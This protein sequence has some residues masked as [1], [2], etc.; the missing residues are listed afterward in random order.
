MRAMILAAGLGTRL[1]PLTNCRPKALVPLRTVTMLQFW[2]ERLSQC[3]FESVC[4]NAFHRKQCLGAAVGLKKWPLPVKV[5]YEPLLLGTAGGIRLGA[6]HGGDTPLAV[7]NADVLSNA[8]LGLLY[9]RHRLSG[10][11]VSL[12]LHDCPQFNNVAVGIDGFV[13]GFGKEAKQICKKD[14]HIRLLAFTGIH[15]LNSSVLAGIPPGVACDIIQV[16]RELIAKNDP[17]AAL[18][19]QDLFWREMGSIQSY[20]KLTLELAKLPASFLAPIIT[21]QTLTIARQARIHPSCRLEGSV[22]IS[23]GVVAGEGVSLENVIIWDNV[24]IEKGSYLKNCIVTDG[25]K[26]F[27]RHTG[28]IFAPEPM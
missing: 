17:P 19:Q 23:P 5:L 27:G 13:L 22:V 2:I 11:G 3:G 1:L 12:L 7:V 26:I 25:M 21:G 15:F 20:R 28:K 6:E 16:Y 10:A 18:F 24:H 4:L 14:H 8:D 9:Q